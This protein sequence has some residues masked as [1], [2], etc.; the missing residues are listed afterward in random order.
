MLL[1]FHTVPLRTCRKSGHF[2]HHWTLAGRLLSLGFSC[3]AAN[4]IFFITQKVAII[5]A[6]GQKGGEFCSCIRFNLTLMRR[7]KRLHFNEHNSGN[8]ISM[9]LQLINTIFFPLFFFYICRVLL[10]LCFLLRRPHQPCSPTWLGC[11]CLKYYI[12]VNILLLVK[13]KK[14][15]LDLSE[16]LHTH[17]VRQGS[18]IPLVATRRSS[19][20]KCFPPELSSLQTFTALTSN[21]NSA[22]STLQVLTMIFFFFFLNLPAHSLIFFSGGSVHPTRTSQAQE[23]FSSFF[24]FFSVPITKVNPPSISNPAPP[25]LCRIMWPPAQELSHR[26][27]KRGQTDAE[28]TNLSFFL[29][30]EEEEE[31]DKQLQALAGVLSGASA[32]YWVHSNLFWPWLMCSVIL[33]FRFSQLLP[34]PFHTESTETHVHLTLP[35]ATSSFNWKLRKWENGNITV[36][37]NSQWTY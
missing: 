31:A 7:C 30:L 16:T 5:A 28:A 9:Q 6:K 19:G 34:F 25:A 21:K 23:R 1:L 22:T 37:E 12:N 10:L 11:Y 36:V 24:F 17:A 13:K 33:R 4:R 8:L 15:L 2:P 3:M 29:Y 32:P 18:A 20:K 27:L 14:R 26:Q 35:G